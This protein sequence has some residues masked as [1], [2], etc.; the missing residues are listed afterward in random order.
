MKIEE[1]GDA[2]ESFSVWASPKLKDEKGKTIVE[3]TQATQKSILRR[4]W[5]RE[6]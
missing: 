1:K 4:Q 6:G 3:R 2:V 5:S